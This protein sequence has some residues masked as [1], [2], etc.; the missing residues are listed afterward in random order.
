ML[1][2][3]SLQ[4]SAPSGTGAVAT[5]T[6]RLPRLDRALDVISTGI[7]TVCTVLITFMLFV[8][9]AA[10]SLQ[11]VSRFWLHS[12]VGAPEELA[13]L[14]MVMMVFVGMPV[15][16]RYFENIRLDVAHELISSAGVREW[17]HRIALA[18]ELVFLVILSILAYQFV[19]QLA[20]ST[21]QSPAL[22]IRIFWSRLPVFVGALLASIVCACM[23]VRRVLGPM[24]ELPDP[25][26]LAI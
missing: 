7:A 9:L 10:V 17:L 6:S 25:Q 20:H 8:S 23:L 26:A 13:R 5:G 24:P 18:A 15:L 1:N 21:Q 3:T 16:V 2:A 11:V 19:E 12:I 14:S 22:G 4:T